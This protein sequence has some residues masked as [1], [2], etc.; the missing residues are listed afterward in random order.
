[1]SEGVRYWTSVA[2]KIFFVFLAA[3]CVG[4]AFKLAVFYMPF[5]IAFIISLIM[6]PFI[7]WIMKKFKVSRKISSILVFIITFGVIIAILSFGIGT[8]I[9]ESTNLLDRFNDYYE[10]IS[11]RMNDI[12]KSID[13][14]KIK[15]PGEILKITQDTSSTIL[16]KTSGLIQKF[17]IS[18]LNMITYIPTFGIYFGITIISLY[19][20]CTDKIYIL[21]EMEHHLPDT[22][23][24]KISKHLREIIRTLGGYLKAQVKLVLIS[25]VIC[26]IRFIYFLFL[27]I[28]CRLSSYDCSGYWLY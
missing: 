25:F 8:L 21:D 28:K 16:E 26:L 23:M 22:W 3:L 5:L 10:N 12:I 14:S 15:I 24:K 11:N 4:L 19:F 6:E 1:M 9:S 18:F 13:F 17:L 20:I 2:K 7:K 27:R